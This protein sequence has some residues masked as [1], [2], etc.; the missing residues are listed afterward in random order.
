MPDAGKK[1]DIKKSQQETVR[2]SPPAASPATKKAPLKASGAE[3]R[4]TK[5]SSGIG[6]DKTIV[7]NQDA[8]II[9]GFK[10]TLAEDPGGTLNAAFA[11]TIL[12]GG[13][14][15]ATVMNQIEKTLAE[16]W[17]DTLIDQQ[18]MTLSLKKTSSA[19]E[20]S[21]SINVSVKSRILSEPSAKP[22]AP[23]EPG[24]HPDYE[25][26]SVLGEGGMGIVYT[27]RQTSVDRTIA[28]KMIKGEGAKNKAHCDKFLSEAAV[29][30]DLDHPNIVPIYDLGVNDQGAVF[31]AMKKVKG[32]PWSDEI[33][34]KDFAENIDI[35]LRVCD[36]VAFAH[37]KGV[38][39]RDLKPENVMLGGYGEV[40]V[41]DW[42]LAVSVDGKGKADVL[43]DKNACSG[44]PCY[45]APEMAYGLSQHIGKHSDVYLMGAILYEIIAGQVP[46][47]GTDV[48]DCLKNAAFNVIQETPVSGELI[49]I[50]YKA[51]SSRPQD[52]YP[53]IKSLKEAIREYQE[54]FESLALTDKARDELKKAGKSREYDDFARALYGFQESIALW[55]H[56]AQAREMEIEARYAYAECAAE[57]ED[58]DLANSLLLDKEESHREL[59]KKVA[60]EL[61]AQNARKFRLKVMTIL[62]VIV[63]V[64]GVTGLSFMLHK[65][66]VA[67]QKAT[68]E[69]ENA[70]AS[71]QRAIKEKARAEIAE[72]DAVAKA[73]EIS[74]Q[75]VQLE[76]QADEL[77]AKKEEA[78]AAQKKAEAAMIE[79][80]E[81]LARAKKEE[82]ERLKAEVEKQK[83]EAQVRYGLDTQLNDWWVFDAEK[84]VAMQAEAAA[85][86]G[87]TVEKEVTLGDGTKLAF[88]LIP[89]GSFGMGSPHTEIDRTGEEYLHRVQ[90][91]K[92]LYLGKFEVTRAQ[93]LGVMGE[94]TG[95]A[96]NI[97]GSI[98]PEHPMT[99]ASWEEVCE[100]FLPEIQKF[101]PEGYRFRL[102]TEAEWEYA[103]RAGT[104]TP[105]YNG[106][107]VEDMQKV[108]WYRGNIDEKSGQS[109][110]PV[111]KLLP[112]AWGLCDMLGNVGEF[113]QDSYDGSFYRENDKAAVVD[114][115]KTGVEN[116]RIYRGGGW[117]NNSGQCRSAYRAW[118][119]P[120][121]AHK[122]IGFRLALEKL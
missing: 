12:E 24:R 86:I 25:L 112:N 97:K 32:K 8:T 4:G 121:N 73:D 44:T 84:A 107:T 77:K 79:A 20:K 91:S 39:H 114:P 42:G 49:D 16:N 67:E 45:M 47:T 54:H 93:W 75:K 100:K 50:A 69:K 62:F 110:M 38:I 18:N 23:S 13:Q 66:R 105:F 11:A 64:G 76:T 113:C 26:L 89:A 119:H 106:K 78:E 56:N 83:A 48:M 81:N 10:K 59:K 40:L 88:R 95:D 2:K 57:K 115:C 80:K 63:L 58:F 71:E 33:K 108:A 82:E 43:T 41:M 101:A 61:K 117:L 27:A 99:Y 65:A 92:S 28:V 122:F 55:S 68:K 103:C 1:E 3:M 6:F 31:Y 17:G 7:E 15:E 90:I 70:L 29:T 30:A 94:L 118:V 21:S 53:D 22:S 104:N 116:K 96:K 5:P 52:R 74:A 60:R 51:M 19:S 109:T 102:P 37:D 46:H 87:E 98:S 9:G 36:A 120:K 14:L 34:K 72:K 111:G 35:F 85:G